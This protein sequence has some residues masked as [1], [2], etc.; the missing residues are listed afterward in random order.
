MNQSAK[1][2]A[3]GVGPG[4]PELLTLKARKALDE[5][6]VVVHDRLVTPEVLELVRREATL[7]LPW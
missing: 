6:D 2:T 5:A 3:V 4:D 1:L 7:I